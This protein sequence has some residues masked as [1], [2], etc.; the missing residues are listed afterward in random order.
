MKPSFC[1]TRVI[2]SCVLLQFGEDAVLTDPYFV[3]RWFWKWN[4]PIGMK[5]SQL[6]KLSAIIGGHSVF[7]HWQIR[8]LESYEF[9]DETPVFVATKSMARKA[10]TV[11]FKTVEVLEWNESRRLSDQLSLEVVPA[12]RTA[13]LT[14]NNYVLST[15]EVRIF[16]GS[17]ALDLEPL[18]QH[19]QR[20][21][22][23]CI[24]VVLA[25]V[26]GARLFSILKLVMNG[27][28]AV[29]ATRILG[30]KT[31]IP[32]HDSQIPV[33]FFFGVPSS[34]ADAEE[35]ARQVD[36]EIEVVRLRPGQQWEYRQ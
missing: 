34:G 27:R 23:P 33:P 32:I 18:R 12:Q 15:P 10:R 31:L 21:N 6:P 29:E 2:N 19:Q 16:Y 14:V 5:V 20:S 9:K 13:G 36:E 17:E 11:G 26:N 3:N 30:S 4:E 22:S 35:E 7:D 28:D 1:V 25:P 8:S 24:D